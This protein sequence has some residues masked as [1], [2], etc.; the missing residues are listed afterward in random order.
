[1]VVS[2]CVLNVRSQTT[3]QASNAFQTEV[4][5][6]L[7]QYANGSELYRTCDVFARKVNFTVAR[8]L[9]LMSEAV[10]PLSSGN[11]TSLDVSRTTADENEPNIAINRKHPNI[12]VGGA[13]DA[14]MTHLS[15]P[16]YLTTDAG[17]SWKTYRLPPVND[18]GSGAFGDPML[19][20][21]DSG[22]FY[23]AFLVDEPSLSGISDIMI[24]RS[25]DGKNWTL[26]KPV[27]GNIDSSNAVL[28]DKETIA[29]DHSPASPFY[30]RLYVAWTEYYIDSPE[31]NAVHYLAYS[32]DHGATWSKPQ[33]YTDAYGY[34]A[35][36]RI[37][38]DGTI[39]IAS[40]NGNDSQP[41][42][43]LVISKD[44]GKTFT[45]NP[46]SD[47]IDYPPLQNGYNGLKGNGFRAFPYVCFDVDPT[48]NKLYA[49]Y[50]SYDDANGDAAEYETTS[51]DLGTSWT[52]PVQIGTPDLIEN[53][54][55]MP[56]VNFDPIERQVFISMYSSEEDTVLNLKTRIVRCNFNTPDQMQSIGNDLFNPLLNTA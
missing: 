15:M 21:D 47:F 34:F 37:G 16:A 31:T 52:D 48:N 25:T 44:G 55:F 45:E 4:R 10:T 39:V 51:A 12:I 2:T 30:G 50:G 17:N 53:D 24:A 27:V 42:H 5:H 35:L 13:N 28:E 32:D 6:I 43:G 22:I 46:I 8:K 38:K 1:C 29:V 9:G 56:W 54:H 19:I 49:V 26:G 3:P 11:D 20:S 40:S 33:S 18:K 41:A 14:A 23:Y 7:A 36:M